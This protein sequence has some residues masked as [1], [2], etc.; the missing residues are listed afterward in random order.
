[1]R[2]F[3]TAIVTI[4]TVVLVGVAADRALAASLCVGSQNGCYA[5]IQIAVDAAQ[6]GDTIAVLPGTYA[7]GI[8]IDKSLH[9]KGAGR[10][11]TAISGGG[12]VIT[13]GVAGA[14]GEPTVSIAGV[15]IRDGVFVGETTVAFGGGLLIPSAANGA[16][17]ATVTVTDS[18]IT[19]NH[20]TPTIAL[21]GGA[22]CPGGPCP[23]ARGDGGGIENWGELTLLR[24]TVSGNEAGGPVASDAHG[25]GIWSAGVGTLTLKNSAVTGN[26]SAVGVP[27]GRFAIGGGVHI[28]DGGGLTINNS[29][30]EGNT[31]A[32]SSIFPT[33]V[34]MLSNGGGIHVGDDSTVTIDNTR[35]DGNA[36]ILETPN[37][38][39]AG[40][41]AG[42]IV[43]ASA[44]V[45]RNSTVSDNRVVANV[46]SSADSGASGSALEFGGTTTISNTRITGNTAT[47]TSQAGTA[48]VAG[49]VAAFA[50]EAAL[51]S[52]SM[53]SGNVQSASS[54]TGR[55]TVQGNGIVNNGVLELRNDQIRDNTG[56]ASGPTGFA[57]GGGIWN[58]LLFNPSSVL[59]LVNTVVTRN[60]LSASTGLIVREEACSPSSR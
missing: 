22:P 12:P 50:P 52:N 3:V 38:D 15:T 53:I 42:M 29:V 25:G 13:I 16:T 9:L 24:T 31:A 58:G 32:I 60:T 45:L 46:G 35:I 39:A 54:A 2:T 27:N 5:T 17:G 4:S 6:N 1:M 56:T 19:G 57:R 49:A 20:A 26:R 43:G 23:F 44:L 7:G 37:A 34:N 10:D 21:P 18:T 40:F 8:V 47:V 33:G 55:A 41:D 59:T 14:M 30:I 36:V 48:A 28:Q 11:A 51:I